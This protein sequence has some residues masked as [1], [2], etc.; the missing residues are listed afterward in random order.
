MKQ[1]CLEG[2]RDQLE[3]DRAATSAGISSSSAAA[4]AD[5]ALGR[6]KDVG[7]PIP[8]TD[9]G[10]FT[11]LQRIEFLHSGSIMRL[12]ANHLRHLPD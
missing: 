12:E 9:W 1:V 4:A 5:H 11:R 10:A 7:L 3:L 2:E 8:S 6:A